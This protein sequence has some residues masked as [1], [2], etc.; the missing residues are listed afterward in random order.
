MNRWISLTSIILPTILCN[1]L[2]ATGK[3]KGSF[4][5]SQT[6]L[7]LYLCISDVL[8]KRD[9]SS[10]GQAAANKVE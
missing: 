7:L 3:L 2:A 10:V 1:V 9:K 4:E 8:K 6:Y 5:Y